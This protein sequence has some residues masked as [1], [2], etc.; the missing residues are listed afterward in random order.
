[1]RSLPCTNSNQFMLKPSSF[2]QVLKNEDKHRQYDEWW[3]S[4]S[5]STSEN[6]FKANL[7]SEAWGG[8]ALRLL[9]CKDSGL[10]LGSAP[11]LGPGLGPG[12]GSRSRYQS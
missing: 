9:L 10:S 2:L 7:R 6:P 8:Y 11:G 12:F 5:G 4:C 3:F 1:M